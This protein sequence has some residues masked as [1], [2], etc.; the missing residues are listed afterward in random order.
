MNAAR[1]TEYAANIG[2]QKIKI[3][4]APADLAQIV[5]IFPPDSAY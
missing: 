4:F 3:R 2:R 5:D 1:R